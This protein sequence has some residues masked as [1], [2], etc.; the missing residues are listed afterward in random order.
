MHQYRVGA[1]LLERSPEEKTWVSWW[2]TGDHEPAVCPGGQE[3]NGTMGCIAQSMASRA[4][5]VL[6][7][8]ALPWG[9]HSWSTAPSVRFPV[10][11][12]QG[13][14]GGSTAEG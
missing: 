3:A 6:L 13:T 11:G 14:A 12:R 10:Q 8:S 9:G 1:A 2:P 5:E 7:P 4:R